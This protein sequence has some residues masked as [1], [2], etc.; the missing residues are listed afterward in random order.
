M[1]LV[2]LESFL[3]LRRGLGGVEV[4]VGRLAPN[5]IK[6]RVKHLI[7]RM[8][9]AKLIILLVIQVEIFWSYLTNSVVCNIRYWIRAGSPDIIQPNQQGLGQVERVSN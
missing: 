9:Y 4:Q 2:K 5:V 3:S 8:F 6:L 7:N 1:L